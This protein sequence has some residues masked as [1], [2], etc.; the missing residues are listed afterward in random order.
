MTRDKGLGEGGSSSKREEKA[1]GN[2][3]LDKTCKAKV[4]GGGTIG[5]ELARTF[6]SHK[7]SLAA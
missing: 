4:A 5:I 3:Y 2:Q 6:L 1:E 7:F